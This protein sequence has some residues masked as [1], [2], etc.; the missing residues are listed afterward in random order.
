MSDERYDLRFYVTGIQDGLKALVDDQL[1]Y[2][3]AV[4]AYGGPPDDDSI[5]NF[6]AQMTPQFPAVLVV[7]GDLAKKLMPGT[8]SAF[9]QPR[10]FRV[11]CLFTAICCDD[12]LRG[13]VERQRG[14]AGSPGVVKMFS[15]VNEALAG[16]Q[17]ARKDDEVVVLVPGKPTPAGHTLLT[18][19]PLTPTGERLLELPGIT[20]YAADFETYFNW[21]EPDRRAETANVSELIFEVDSTGAN[22][23]P[24]DKPGVVVK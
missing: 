13:E 2:L 7:F 8:S 5:V 9:G 17:L 12:N 3:K 23:E 20:C 19:G 6:I 18:Q 14:D 1:S 11:D 21:S 15:D 24:G 10:T 22:K 4:E 16:R